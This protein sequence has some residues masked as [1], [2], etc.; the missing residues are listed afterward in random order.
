MKDITI[1]IVGKRFNGETTEDEMEFVSDGTMY[2][3]GGAIYYIYEESEFSGMPG[4]KT[5]LKVTEDRI[6]MKRIGNA[7]ASFGAELVFEKGKRF[8]S[9]YATPYG[10]IDME[11]MT[12]RVDAELDPEG[13]GRIRLDYSVC[14]EGMS[15]GRNQVDIEIMQ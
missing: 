2:E 9:R 10:P 12:N 7:E 13:F 8:I 11:V 5:S 1:K 4:C 15:E 3:R 14:M 6:R